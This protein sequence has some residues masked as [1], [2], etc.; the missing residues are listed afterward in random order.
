M[1]DLS[2][3]ININRLKP[4]IYD[5]LFQSELRNKYIVDIEDNINNIKL[6]SA[7]TK[8]N[9]LSNEEIEKK[10]K[11]YK[12]QNRI[13]ILGANQYSNIQFIENKVKE[14]DIK[15]QGFKEEIEKNG[16]KKFEIY[17]KKENIIINKKLLDKE[18]FFK[19]LLGTHE[20][21]ASDRKIINS[22]L[23]LYKT[24][25]V[26]TKKGEKDNVL[27]DEIVKKE[28]E[29]KLLNLKRYKKIPNNKCPVFYNFISNILNISE[30]EMK[31]AYDTIGGSTLTIKSFINPN[32]Y[33]QCPFIRSLIFNYYKHYDF[34]SNSNVKTSIFEENSDIKNYVENSKIAKYIIRKN[35]IVNIFSKYWKDIVYDNKFKHFITYLITCYMIDKCYPLAELGTGISKKISVKKIDDSTIKNI[36]VMCNY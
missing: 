32:V 2:I 28:Y 16:Q 25:L 17:Q 26:K 7:P 15:I 31:R 29:L 23:L 8:K 34:I 30:N 24:L 36:L 18:D 35:H 22:L 12:E 27:I 4:V 19:K 5:L 10:I 9:K 21:S 3:R 11:L 13:F 6:L 1:E 33:N 14:F 20:K